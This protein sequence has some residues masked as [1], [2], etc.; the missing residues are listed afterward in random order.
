MT[1]ISAIIKQKRKSL[2]LTQVELSIKPGLVLRQI[3]EIGQGKTS[4]CVDKV[5]LAPTLFGMELA[6]APKQRNDD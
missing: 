4:I 1:S 5:H 2:K 3:R 6:P